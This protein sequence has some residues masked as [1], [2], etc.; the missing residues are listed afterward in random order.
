MA[1][2]N[3]SLLPGHH[4]LDLVETT[5]RFHGGTVAPDLD[6]Q[7]THVL[8]LGAGEEEEEEVDRDPVA[9]DP[10]LLSELKLERRRREK[11]FHI[12]TQRWVEECLD[13]VDIVQEREPR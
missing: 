2:G 4:P 8:V 10:D 12:V 1:R 11:K 13:R 7:V 5:L 3:E 9:S 6:A